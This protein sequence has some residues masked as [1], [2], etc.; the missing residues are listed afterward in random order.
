MKSITKKQVV[1]F[2]RNQLG[3]NPAWA[4]KAMVRIFKENQTEAEQVTQITRE[5]NGTGFNGIDAGILSS[6]SQ[7]V[8]DG[9]SLSPKQMAIIFKKL[10]KYSSQVIKFSDQ[11]KLISL[12]EASH[13]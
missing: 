13:S 9:R 7:Q 4:V 6:F 11:S 12:V 1:S 5:D 3:T 8:I 10:P 2:V